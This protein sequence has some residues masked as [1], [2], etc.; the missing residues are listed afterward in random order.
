MWSLPAECYYD[1]ATAP[2]SLRSAHCALH[3]PMR[4]PSPRPPAFSPLCP[5]ANGCRH[6]AGAGRDPANYNGYRSYGIE[7]PFDRGR[8]VPA[9]CSC[10]R[11]VLTPDMRQSHASGVITPS[12]S[13]NLR[14]RHQLV[15]HSLVYRN[16]DHDDC[17]ALPH[18]GE[19]PPEVLQ[20]VT[21]SSRTP[22]LPVRLRQPASHLCYKDR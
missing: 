19:P 1:R 13:P 22:C 7:V 20:C 18:H 8:S 10:A 17:L 2:S 12:V 3:R 4:T 6:S 21:R 15:L 14:H 9:P 16:R 11:P 5:H